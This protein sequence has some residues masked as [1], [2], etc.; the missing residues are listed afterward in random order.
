MN[1]AEIKLQPEDLRGIKVI[2][3]H[4]YEAP[5]EDIAK[6]AQLKLLEWLKGKC[7]DHPLKFTV[8][9]SGRAITQPEYHYQKRLYCPVCMSEIEKLLKGGE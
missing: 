1:L 5:I 3:K 7:I 2:F 6:A 9:T 8:D 4:V